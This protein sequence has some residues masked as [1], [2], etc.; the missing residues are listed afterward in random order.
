MEI[1]SAASVVSSQSTTRPI[2]SR[3]ASSLWL[4]GATASISSPTGYAKTPSRR[5]KA[6]S[7]AASVHVAD[8]RRQARSALEVREIGG[9]AVPRLGRK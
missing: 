1:A 9:E 7:S 4:S 5:R 3:G 6:S 8:V 2:S